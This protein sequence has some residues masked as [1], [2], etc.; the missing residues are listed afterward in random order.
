MVQGGYE[1]AIRD[2]K[3]YEVATRGVMWVQCK[4]K[5]CEAGMRHLQGGMVGMSW[6]QVI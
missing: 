2:A 4:Y 3:G 1:A 5:R 6:L